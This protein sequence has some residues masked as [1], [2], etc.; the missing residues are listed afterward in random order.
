MFW[1]VSRSLPLA[2]KTQQEGSWKTPV[3]QVPQAG[4]VE[5]GGWAER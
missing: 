4:G 1:L 3:Y 2:G 5:A